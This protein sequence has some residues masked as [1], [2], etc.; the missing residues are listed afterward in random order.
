MTRGWNLTKAACLIA[1]IFV[2]A[3]P[4]AVLAQSQFPSRSITVVVPLPPGG[5]AD[6]LPRLV[7]E[8]LSQHWGQPVVI[9]NKP[10]AALNIGAEMVSRAAPDGYTLLATPAGPLATNRF[11]FKKLPFDPD[12]FVPVTVLARGPFILVARPDLP[13][14]SLKELI[15]YAKANP[16]KVTY[17]SSGSGSPPQLAMELLAQQ[18]GIRLLH[19]PFK[20]LAPALNAV[21]AGQIDLIFH[22]FPSTMPQIKADTV[23]ALGVGSENRLAQLPQVPAIAEVLPGFSSGFWYAV[24]A[25]QGTSPAI[26]AKLSAAMADA[27]HSPDIAAKLDKFAISSGGDTP[28]ATAA[29]LKREIEHWHA[30][31]V[32]A[33]IQAADR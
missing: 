3:A 25:P 30:A 10:G 18:A 9:V 1:A 27:V 31:V 22:D 14:S 23:K 24:V 21:M 32:A 7:A 17:A 15:A 2:G 5:F 16:G 29:F 26:V 12:A 19:V 11:V 20:G 6:I 33:G 8:K 13:V 28:A 4:L